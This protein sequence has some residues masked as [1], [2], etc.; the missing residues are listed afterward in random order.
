M[1]VGDGEVVGA[2][3]IVSVNR[4]TFIIDCVLVP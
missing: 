2:F 3:V 1:V 4:D